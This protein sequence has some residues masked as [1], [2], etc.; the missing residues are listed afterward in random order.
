M[1]R[2]S[3]FPVHPRELVLRTLKKQRKPLSAYALLAA[4]KPRGVTAAPVIYRALAELM[5]QG[6]VHKV[7]ELG[8]FIACDC[9]AKTPH[10]AHTLSVLTVCSQCS[11]VAELHDPAVIARLEALR[12]HGITLAAQAVIELPVTCAR[13][14]A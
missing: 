10:A 9:A 2:P 12:S 13:C 3:S 11:A 6:R 7:K 8:A 1:G 14:A 5:A 4:L